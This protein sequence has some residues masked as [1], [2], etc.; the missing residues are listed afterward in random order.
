MFVNLYNYVRQWHHHKTFLCS[1][2]SSYHWTFRKAIQ[3]YF[4]QEA[5]CMSNS[6]N[7]EYFLLKKNDAILNA[8]SNLCQE[9][10]G[11]R[12]SFMTKKELW[13]RYKWLKDVLFLIY[14]VGQDKLT[15]L[16]S[17]IHAVIHNATPFIY[18]SFMCK[19]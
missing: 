12:I 16:I 17:K 3:W 7:A 10:P 5:S 13:I 6:P 18:Q 1:D 19:S 8:F 15:M 11:K 14:S 2:V 4:V 9:W